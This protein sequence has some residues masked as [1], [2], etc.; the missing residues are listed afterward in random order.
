[1][2]LKDKNIGS[3]LTLIS[4]NDPTID[5][6]GVDLF[7]EACTEHSAAINELPEKAKKLA[8]F[9]R[10]NPDTYSIIAAVASTPGMIPIAQLA[11]E[12]GQNESTVRNRIH[13]ARKL[14]KLKRWEK[15]GGTVLVDRKEGLRIAEAVGQPMAKVGRPRNPR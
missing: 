15:Q 11:I 9:V 10:E 14:G 2:E 8:S 13:R 12:S 1:M 5:Q 3:G 7:L 6:K 4:A